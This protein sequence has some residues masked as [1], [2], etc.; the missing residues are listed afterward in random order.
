MN[1][2]AHRTT[3]ICVLFFAAA[4]VIVALLL[5]LYLCCCWCCSTAAFFS[6]SFCFCFEEFSAFA[7]YKIS[8]ESEMISKTQRICERMNE[9]TSYIFLGSCVVVNRGVSG[10]YFVNTDTWRAT[11][12]CVLNIIKLLSRCT[13]SYDSWFMQYTQQSTWYS[14]FEYKYYSFFYDVNDK[15]SKKNGIKYRKKKVKEKNERKM[16]R[17]NTKHSLDY[18]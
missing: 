14:Q 16:R 1:S 7:D 17:K 8:F 13:K 10:V 18:Y 9:R 3:T 12:I 2:H 11:H 6:R 15:W 4:V 5:V